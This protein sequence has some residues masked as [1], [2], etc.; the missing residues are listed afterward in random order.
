MIYSRTEAVGYYQEQS[1]ATALPFIFLN[2]GVSTKLLQG[3]LGLLLRR[4]DYHLVAL[5]VVG[6]LGVKG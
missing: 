4:S 6:L 1:E 5:F 3:S 2:A